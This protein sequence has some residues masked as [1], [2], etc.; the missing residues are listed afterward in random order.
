M[1]HVVLEHLRLTP[2]G[3]QVDLSAG[4]F[5]IDAGPVTLYPLVVARAGVTNSTFT[6]RIGVG[7]ALDPAGASSVE[8]RW[9]LD[10][11]PPA[12]YDVTRDVAGVETSADGTLSVVG[13]DA[14]GLAVSLASSVITTQLGTVVTTR[15]TGMLQGVVFTG[16]GRAIDT[17]LFADLTSPERLLHRLKVLAWNCATDPAHGGQPASSGERDDRRD[18]DDRL[19][20]R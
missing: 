10:G 14:L 4:P 8:V 13:L 11:S 12:P 16:G 17:T 18:R 6:R 20:G 2:T 9:T 5:T 1:G 19:G 7:L 3:I 15:A